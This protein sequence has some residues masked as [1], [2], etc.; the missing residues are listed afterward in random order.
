MTTVLHVLSQRPQQTGSGITLDAF[1][2][3]AAALGWRQHVVVGVPAQ[4]RTVAVGDL[5]EA[6]I[7]PL[8][9]ET[10][11]LPFPVPGMSDV[12]PYCS[13]CFSGMDTATLTAYIEAWTKHLREVIA[14]T[15]PDVIHAHH[16][17]LVSS[18]IKD[19]APTTPVVNQC[20]ATGFRQMELCPHLAP[21]VTAG[22]RR[23]ERFLVAHD[24]Q[25]KELVARLGVDAGRVSVIGAGYHQEAFHFREG[26]DRS[27]P[28]V[29]YA[30]KTSR[31]KGVPWLLDAVALLSKRIP[32][33]VLEIAGSGAGEEAAAVRQ[34]AEAL[35]SHVRLH[36][37]LAQ[38]DLADLFRC[39]RVCVLPSFYEGLPLVLV[40]AMACGC[41]LVA[42]ELP[43]I[44]AS[45]LSELR[46]WMTTVP[47]PRLRNVDEPF[48]R[49]LPAFTSNLAD[50]MQHALE[51]PPANPADPAYCET[52]AA[53]TWEAVF[54]RVE[55]DWRELLAN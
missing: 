12:M 47:L 52:L 30:G 53:F 48:D 40:E 16:L 26:V 5:P 17:W 54:G 8:L 49:D 18:L 25:A 6:N 27:V 9:F 51:Q 43:S 38:H 15:K 31:A 37:Q 55:H 39:S 42:T 19:L 44:A 23:N 1:V 46:P 20:H 28:R 36:G 45:R 33:V 2:R 7:H 35:G 22:C 13:T 14:Q 32:D 10:P 24:G 41:R 34:R 4:E 29:A 3:H 50:A 21:R 11:E